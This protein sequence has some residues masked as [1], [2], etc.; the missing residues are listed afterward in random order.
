M[1]SRVK[2]FGHPLHQQLIPLPLGLLPASVAFDI[3]A[4]VTGNPMFY[5]VAFWLV[6]AGVATGLLAAVFGIIDWSAIP[7]GTRAKAVGLYH[8]VTNVAGITLFIIGWVLRRDALAAV[9]ENIAVIPVLLSVIALGINMVAAWFG[10][11]L[12]DRLGVGV[13]KGA[14]LDAPSSLSDR[15]AAENAAGPMQTPTG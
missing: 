3:I 14:H 13:D 5:R 10:G 9:P 4:L 12:V 8:M 6:G 11:E 2:L 1:E 15:P 7:S